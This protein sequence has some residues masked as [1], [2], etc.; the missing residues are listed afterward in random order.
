MSKFKKLLIILISILIVEAIIIYCGYKSSSNKN[1]FNINNSKS[2][3]IILVDVSSNNLIVFKDGIQFKLYKIASGKYNTPSPLGTW[4]IVKKDN[5]G[6]GFGGYWMGFNVPWGKYGIHGTLFP[7]SIGWNSSHGC[8]R[9]KNS[10]VA[11]LYKFIPYGTTV[12]VW[13]GPYGNFGSH[14]RTLKPGMT[15]SDVY[16]LQFILQARGYY[17]SKPNGIYTDYFKSVVHKFQKD[18]SLPTSDTIGYS[19]YS[20]LGIKLVD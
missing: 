6:D 5:W 1:A 16:Q 15:G 14:L 10:E 4:K 9:M 18:N 7:N 13:G 19:F 17:N 11:E 3:Y 20:K 8:I 2:T 12:I